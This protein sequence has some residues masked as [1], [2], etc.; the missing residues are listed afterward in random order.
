MPTLMTLTRIMVVNLIYSK[1][2][3]CVCAIHVNFM[4]MVTSTDAYSEQTAMTQ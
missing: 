1:S 3:E 2:I 4:C